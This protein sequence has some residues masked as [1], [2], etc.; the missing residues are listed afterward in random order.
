MYAA[1]K[2]ELGAVFSEY[3]RL[4]SELPSV[5]SPAAVEEFFTGE[6]ADQYFE[7]MVAAAPPEIRADQEMI[8]RWDREWLS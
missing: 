3:G 2:D 4:L 5:A 6:T 1:G 8:S 7:D